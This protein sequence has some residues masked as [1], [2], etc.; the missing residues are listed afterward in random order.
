MAR[1]DKI[2]A[3]AMTE[4]RKTC[5]LAS[6]MLPS[7]ISEKGTSSGTTGSV[8]VPA[9]ICVAPRVSASISGSRSEKR[10]DHWRPCSADSG[11]M[12]RRYC[13]S[14]WAGLGQEEGPV[15]WPSSGLVSGIIWE[16]GQAARPSGTTHARAG[17]T[18]RAWTSHAGSGDRTASSRSFAGSGST[19]NII[20]TNGICVSATTGRTV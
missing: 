8:A 13:R 3:Y 7:T 9:T 16:K 5:T 15:T 12:Q 4:R 6:A 20:P 17:I 19:P 18:S 11:S 14:S 10:R 2:S 1:I